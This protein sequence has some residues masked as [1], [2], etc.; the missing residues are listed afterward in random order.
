MVLDLTVKVATPLAFV[1]AG[2]PV[3]VAVPEEIP[4]LMDLPET[5]LLFESSNVTVIVDVPVSSA[6]TEVGEA[7]TEEFAEFPT[8]LVK[9]TVAV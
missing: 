6:I 4:K 2:D 1:V 7:M 3:I 9:L 5:G 8:G